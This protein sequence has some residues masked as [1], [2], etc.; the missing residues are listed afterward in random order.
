[1]RE[2]SECAMTE[3]AQGSDYNDVQDTSV[4]NEGIAP[5]PMTNYFGLVLLGCLNWLVF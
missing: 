1:M 4:V 2:V 5:V 3:W